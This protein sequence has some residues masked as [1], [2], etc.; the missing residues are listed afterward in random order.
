MLIK[1]LNLKNFRQFYGNQTIDFSTDK[2]NKI[3]FVMAESGVGKTTLL[4]SFQWILYGTSKFNIVLNKKIENSMDLNSKE[5]VVGNLL[6]NHGNID[7]SITRKEVFFKNSNSVR[8]DGMTIQIDYKNSDGISMQKKGKDADFIIKKIMHRDL[9]PYFFLEGES[10]TKVGEQM[11]KGKLGSNS[12]FVKAIRGL[13]NFNFL[14]EEKKH[15]NSV[16]KEYDEEIGRNTSNFKL[17]KIIKEISLHD[18]TISEKQERNIHIDEEL[19]DYKE[20]RDEISDNLIQIGEIASDQKRAKQLSFELPNI[21]EQI[22]KKEK[23]IF[24]KFSNC[25]FY[26]IANSLLNDV[27]EVLKNSDNIDKGVPGMN[28]DSI[29]YLLKNHKCICGEELIEGSQHWNILNDLLNY[30]PPNNI[31]TELKTFSDEMKQIENRSKLFRD[32]IVNLRRELSETIKNYNSKFDELN[33]INEKISG[34][35][36]DVN[37]LKTKESEYNSKI[38]NLNSEKGRNIVKIEEL[39]SKIK[40]LNIERDFWQKQDEKTKKIQCYRDEAQFLENRII[41]YINQKEKSKKEQLTK[42]IN[43]IFKD[44]YKEN[45]SF[46]LDDNYGVHIQTSDEEFLNDFTSGGQDVAIALAFIGAI[47]KASGAKEGKENDPL[48]DS[49]ENKELYPLVLDAPTSNF[50]MKQMNSFAETMPKITDQIIVFINDKDGPILK[51]I[52]HNKIGM[53]WNLYKKEG[54]SYYTTMEKKDD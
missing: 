1:S 10:L 25:G 11:A 16:I 4:Q 13:L 2:D 44:F 20:K 38:E 12:D 8:S 27:R 41:Q 33:E 45:I 42:Y 53:T 9:F 52:L 19:I 5:E 6:I 17:Q 28:I 29:N 50:G 46:V 24:D 32:D 48:D 14:Y 15:L 34:V 54:D 3:T 40:G 26:F 31:G 30:L 36:I 35:S 7:F 21:K 47:I 18:S 23:M 51:N 22:S 49:E 43:E 37:A 39:N